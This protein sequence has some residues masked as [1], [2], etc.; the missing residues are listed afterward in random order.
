[1]NR[2]PPVEFLSEDEIESIHQASLTVLRDIG[3]SFMH[4]EALKILKEHGAEIVPD[5]DVVK[6]DPALVEEYIAKVPPT[7]TLR[8]RNPDSVHTIGG[9][10]IVVG[11]VSSAPNCSDLDNGHRPGNQKDYENLLRLN[12][13]F[14]VFSFVGGYPVEPADLPPETRHLDASEAMLRLSD[15]PFYG[16]SLGR[17]RILDSIEICRRGLGISDTELLQ[18]AYLM[19]VVNTSS[20]MRLDAPMIE[21]IIE[22]AQVRQPVII[23]PFTLSGAMAPAS[24]SGALVSQNAE[25]LASIAFMQ[26]VNAGAPLVYGT[27]TS[28]VDMKSGAPAFGT[29]EYVKTTMASGQLG[30]RYKIPMRASNACAANA[31]DGQAAYESMF[32][33]WSFVLGGIHVCKHGAGWLEGGLVASFE[34][35]ILDVEILQNFLEM[36]EPIAMDSDSMALEAIREVGQGGHFFGAA[37]TMARYDSA[38]Y[39]PMVS[40]W[41]NHGAWEEAGSPQTAEH[42]NRIWKQALAEYQEPY[43][44]P[45]RAESVRE[46]IE[47]R[48]EQGGSESLPD[49]AA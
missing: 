12:Q 15:K 44:D 36:M 17:A 41:R 4:P 39:S 28:N 18:D 22:M 6:F 43:W 40:D 23:T 20:P 32:S 14:N 35:L 34:K 47:L 21:G 2:F 25:A 10:E 7:F 31:V 24:L 1:M 3:M 16:Y 8:G 46:Y 13:Y 49:H 38:F 37:H 27:F 45:A 5:T 30:R 42:C 11:T 26:M 9:K 33:L 48:R 19:T 29:P